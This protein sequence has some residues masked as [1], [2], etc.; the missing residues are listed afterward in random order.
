MKVSDRLRMFTGNAHRALAEKVCDYLEI[1]LGIVDVGRFMDEEIY[2]R[3]KENIRG[4]DVFVFQPTFS[5][6]ENLLELLIMLDAVRRASA[7]RVVAVIPY[8]GYARQ[9]R[10]DQPRVAITAKL[11]ANL[12]VSAGATRVVTMDLHSA[13]IQGFFDIPFDH[14]FAAPILID[15][16]KDKHIEKP[17]IL[18]P[19][20]GSVKMARAYAKRLDAGL[21]ITDKRRP[22]PDKAEVVNVIGDVKDKNVVIIDDMISTG[23]S[24][25]NAALAA[26]ARGAGDVYAACTHAVFCGESM[27]NLAEA[28]LKEIVVTDTVPSDPVKMLGNINVLSVAPLLGEAA[29]RIHE[30]RSLSSLFV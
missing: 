23:G 2:V 12:I 29:R 3:I 30:E 1:P 20:V 6:A 18:A 21:A 24:M 10:K 9:D 14:L 4:Q 15:Y 11:V 16:F 27:K 22:A 28:E 7:K 8:F 17:V 19:D 26:K 25:K 13:Q 5:P